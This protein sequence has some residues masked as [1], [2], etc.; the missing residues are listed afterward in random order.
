MNNKPDFLSL[1][2]RDS[3][4]KRVNQAY[5][6]IRAVITVKDS[7]PLLSITDVSLNPVHPDAKD[8]KGAHARL[9]GACRRISESMATSFDWMKE[10]TAPEQI[11]IADYP[12]I[13]PLLI[14]CA[15]ILVDNSG[16]PYSI[17]NESKPLLFA[18][19]REN[20]ENGIPGRFKGNFTIAGTIVRC[21]ISDQYAIGDNKIMRIRSVGQQFASLMSLTQSVD[22]RFLEIYL[23]IFFSAVSNVNVVVEGHDIIFTENFVKY[24]STIIFEK[25]DSDNALYLRVTDSIG[26]IPPEFTNDI[27]LSRVAE[28]EGNRII[29]RTL[30]ESNVETT[31][32]EVMQSV[33]SAAPSRALA[34]EIW[35]EGNLMIIPAEVASEFLSRKLPS[36]L[37]TYRL[38]GADKLRPY[39]ITAARP[40]LNLK[41]GSGI[42]FLEGKATVD[43]AGQTFTISDLLNQYTRTRYITLSDGTRAFV[44]D[45]YMK[46][47]QRIFSRARS[48]GD[49]VKVSFF[50]LPEIMEILNAEESQEKAFALYRNFYEGFG[51]LPSKQIEIPGLKATL[52]SYQTEGVKWLDYLYTNGMGG[53]LADDMGL[54]KTVQTIAMLCRTVPGQQ[55]PSLIIMPRSLLFN[56]E[57][58]FARFAPHISVATYYGTTRDLNESLK[59]DVILTSYA[60]V[61][62]DIRQFVEHEFDYIILDESQNIK[63]VDAMMTKAVWLLK[64]RHRLA[65]S[66]TPVENN[67]SELYSLFRFLNPTMFGSHREFNDRYAVPIQK[68]GDSDAATALR[69]R[70]FPFILRRLKR[71]VIVDLPERT[72]QTLVVEMSERHAAFYEERRSYF[73]GEVSAAMQ[74]RGIDKARFELLKALGEL[75]QI[76]SVPEEKT[77]GAIESPKIELL[78]TNV[79]QAVENGHKVV[80]FYNFLAGIELT[81]QQLEKAGVGYDIMTGAT[82]NRQRVIENFSDN[83]DCKVLLMTV[84]TGGV[85]LNLVC[86]DTVFIVEPW[87]NKAAEDQAINRLHRIGQKNAVNCYYLI[88]AGTIEEKIRQLQEQKSALI[89]TVISSDS[90]GKTLSPQ[91]IEYLLS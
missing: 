15:D 76:A 71:D 88:T 1:L 46:R 48:K 50:D 37:T 61:R 84:K 58:E 77:D 2:R 23:S 82:Q 41:L 73:S 83:P 89:D 60:V 53:C 35:S 3:G 86:A 10:Y 85:G 68:E 67:L 39:R 26:N 36:M 62:N 19:H 79:L 47:L 78:M 40:S 17:E 11:P 75:R 16:N 14:D 24:V 33:M 9:A 25:V 72:E 18:I 59:A 80:V 13:V 52:R 87:W 57:Q 45:T 20:Y 91:D 21:F 31:F 4:T 63:N 49:K 38:I 6:E 55:S 54:G 65:I 27:T 34:K 12:F 42:D 51:K 90:A 22:L 30:A 28:L 70:I 66:G 44:D 43:V 32:S 81:A 64:G 56:W 29:V 69:T 74:I 7:I 8:L 5:S